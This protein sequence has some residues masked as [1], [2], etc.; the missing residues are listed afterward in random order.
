[1]HTNDE[2][3][4]WIR[5][6]DFSCFLSFILEQTMY[7]RNKLVP[8]TWVERGNGWSI[9]NDVEISCYN[10]TILPKFHC[11]CNR[12]IEE[13]TIDSYL[14]WGKIENMSTNVVRHILMVSFCRMNVTG[15]NSRISEYHK[16]TLGI[17]TR[18]KD[19]DEGFTA[20]VFKKGEFPWILWSRL[21]HAL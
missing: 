18:V 11:S 19:V 5:I 10:A 3:N 17:Y 9:D 2:L 15:D 20:P 14:Y 7:Y 21:L 4:L 8:N 13:K 1:M 12:W 16:N 6:Y